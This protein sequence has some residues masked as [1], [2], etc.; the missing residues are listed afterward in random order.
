V[1][2]TAKDALATTREIRYIEVPFSDKWSAIASQ[3][4][5][6]LHP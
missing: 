4:L 3:M 6:I 5:V 2:M 1:T